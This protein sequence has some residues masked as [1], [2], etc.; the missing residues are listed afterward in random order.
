MRSRRDRPL[1]VNGPVSARSTIRRSR[2]GSDGSRRR[3]ARSRRLRRRRG[4]RRASAARRRA[5]PRSRRS[6]HAPGRQRGEP[7]GCRDPRSRAPAPAHRTTATARS[8][9]TPDAGR[10]RRRRRAAT[11]AVRV[12]RAVAVRRH[13][14]DFSAGGARRSDDASIAGVI[15]QGQAC[16]VRHDHD[17]RAGASSAR[18]GIDDR[19]RVPRAR[20]RSRATR[21]ACGG[22]RSAPSCRP[23]TVSNAGGPTSNAKPTSRLAPGRVQRPPLA[24]GASSPPLSPPPLPWSSQV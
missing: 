17:A 15:A 10:R 5:D 19:G 22:R 21:C 9:S 4:A 7:G 13:E 23:L 2:E 11:Y 24:V 8:R 14:R 6:P 20:S 16:A 18:G 1:D 3:A 12:Q